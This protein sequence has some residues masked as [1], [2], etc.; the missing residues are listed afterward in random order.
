MNIEP[1]C[2]FL[3]LHD[4][5]CHSYCMENTNSTPLPAH[6][7]PH[8]H[9]I[10]DMFH[11]PIVLF[12]AIVIVVVTLL[13]GWYLYTNAGLIPSSTPQQ[14]AKPTATL[15]PSSPTPTRT[16][17]EGGVGADW[18][19]QLD[20]DCGVT[21]FIPPAQEPYL[22]PRDPNTPPSATDDE[23][24]Y[25]IYEKNDVNLFLFKR[26]ARVIFKN[27][28]APG[29]GYVSGAVEVMC[30]PNTEKYTTDSLFVKI[31]ED[32]LQNFS[33]ISL[34]S[35][36]GANLWGRDVKTA[37]FQGGSFNDDTYYLFATDSHIY[38]IRRTGE[39]SNSEVQ[40]VRDNILL[41]MEFE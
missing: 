28:E 6:L 34:A 18:T 39:S 10:N 1:S 40:Q 23:G 7:M 21:L 8:K 17:E 3:A 27:P 9:G 13:G 29:S 5:F 16:V 15:P 14:A 22:I 12:F 30:A 4:L 38:M 37:I 33:V 2:K 35:S 20:S 25:W 24:K 31:Q 19:R 36:G 26:M 41:N 32:L 11:M